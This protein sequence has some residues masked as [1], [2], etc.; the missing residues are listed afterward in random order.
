MNNLYSILGWIN[1][2]TFL[3]IIIPIAIKQLAKNKASVVFKF[4]KSLSKRHKVFALSFIVTTIWHGYLALRG[5]YLHTGTILALFV[6]VT[7]V[8]GVLFEQLKIKRLFK[9][10]SVF[11]LLVIVMLLIHL[12]LPALF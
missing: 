6:I 12:T 3:L 1:V 7:G 5:L 10:H 8:L 9:L 2:L 11:G 4:A